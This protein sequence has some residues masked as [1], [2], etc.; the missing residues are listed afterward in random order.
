MDEAPLLVITNYEVTYFIK[1]DLEDVE[2][3]RLWV[4]PPVS[5]D[6][7]S[8]PPLAAWLFFA[9]YA[10]QLWDGQVKSR[11]GRAQVP[12]TPT[13]GYPV[14]AYFVDKAG[15][16][17]APER[18]QPARGQRSSGRENQQQQGQQQ[19][20]QQEDH[21]PDNPNLDDGLQGY[22]EGTDWELGMSSR[23]ASSGSYGSGSLRSSISSS[24]PES[25]SSRSSSQGGVSRLPDPQCWSALK[26]TG[27]AAIV[28]AL[29]M[30]PDSVV[31]YTD[32]LLSATSSSVVV[33]VRRGG[34]V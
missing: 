5:W 21:G 9:K 7:K 17:Q 27:P 6:S 28:D 12:L 25:S 10:L 18:Q 11:L 29:N 15:W 14:G 19:Q 31:H 33:K 1:R 32:W 20:Q 3:K 22:S 30:L 16:R 23:R 34:L 13:G 24:I 2:N 8:P 4:S 26:Q